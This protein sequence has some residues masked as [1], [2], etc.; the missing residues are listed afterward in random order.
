MRVVNFL[1]ILFFTPQQQKPEPGCCA[2]RRRLHGM[3]GYNL[4]CRASFLHVE[5]FRLKLGF[6]VFPLAWDGPP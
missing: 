6:L 5:P 2:W 3:D 4:A 1:V